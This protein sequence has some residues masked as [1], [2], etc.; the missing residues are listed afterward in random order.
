MCYLLETFQSDGEEEEV[1]VSGGI[2]EKHQSTVP[3]VLRLR[4]LYVCNVWVSLANARAPHQTAA[5]RPA[6][7]WPRSTSSTRARA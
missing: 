7:A 2:L 3:Q 6:P 4:D 5:S 1:V